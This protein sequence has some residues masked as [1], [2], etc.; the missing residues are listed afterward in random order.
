[1]ALRLVVMVEYLPLVQ[2]MVHYS[3]H[4]L[5]PGLI[6]WIVFR[7]Q[8]KKA[9]LIMLATMLVDLDHLFAWPDVFVPDRCGIGFHPLHSYP[10]IAVYAVGCFFRPL[11]IVAVGLLFH[12]VTDFQ[13]CVW[14]RC[15]S[16]M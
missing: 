10:A 3:L 7:K 13:D 12:M 15:L 11:R 8:W 14:M 5:A 6:A 1:M 2:S 9:W 16:S 4:L